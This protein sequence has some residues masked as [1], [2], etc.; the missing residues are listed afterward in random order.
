M[1]NAVIN[2]L[3]LVGNCLTVTI[4]FP[5]IQILNGYQLPSSQQNR[6]IS[7]HCYFTLMFI[8]LW[9]S[10]KKKWE[11]TLCFLLREREQNK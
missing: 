11:D 7:K 8:G 3:C 4:A 10:K 5:H 6:L 9:L 2:G 1:F